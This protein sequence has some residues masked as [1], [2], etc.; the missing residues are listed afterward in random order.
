M[1]AERFL[2]FSLF[3]MRKKKQLNNEL[4]MHLLI[5]KGHPHHGNEKRTLF[6]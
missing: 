1:A 3:P 2:R 5:K 4:K 6:L